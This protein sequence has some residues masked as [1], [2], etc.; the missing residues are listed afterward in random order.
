VLGLVARKGVKGVQAQVLDQCEAAVQDSGMLER[1]MESAAPVSLPGAL[2]AP[3]QDE[4]TE[5]EGPGPC[6]GVPIL[7]RG[8]ALGVLSV[9]RDAGQPEHSEDEVALLS[10]VARRVG[11]I[12]EGA[13][14]REAAEQA[15]V[16]QERQ[17]LARDL[18]DSVTQSLYSLTLLSEITRRSAQ[19]ADLDGVAYHVH[20]LGEVAQQAL[21]EMRLLIY[22][23]RPLA[24]EREGLVG[25]L[26]Q[27]L[28]AVEGRAEVEARL[29]VEGEGNLAEPVEAALYHIA[30]EALNNA[31]K[32]SGASGVTVKLR[33]AGPETKLEVV[34][35]GRGFDLDGVADSVG[36][37]LA[38]M[39]QRA[40]GIGAA[41]SI[42]SI[43][44]E[45]TVIAVDVGQGDEA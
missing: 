9:A 22:E 4:E 5:L 13:R 26:Q 30:L 11:T 27:R 6:V 7:L 34:D 41:L 3:P 28:D 18:H 29:L 33:L 42:H 10:S 37:G 39:R 43:P 23:L 17:R 20:R 19:A 15:A 1:V 8:E 16:L 44:G 2:A 40:E 25:A 21:K 24:L 38:T 32:H 45:G 12:V 14:L 36:M 31:L 35:N